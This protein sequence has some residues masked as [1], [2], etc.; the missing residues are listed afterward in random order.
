M[1]ARQWLAVLAASLPLVAG[2]CGD[3]GTPTGPR[4]SL[5]R[6]Q[7]APVDPLACSFSNAKNLAQSEFTNSTTRT[8]ARNL[9]DAMSSAGQY[10]AGAKS[11]GFSVMALIASAKKAN[12]AKDAATGSDLTNALIVCMFDPTGP[13]FPASFPIDFKPSLDRGQSGAYEVRGST[14]DALA[15]LSFPT[16]AFPRISGLTPATAS[17]SGVLHETTLIYGLPVAGTNGPDPD[18]YEWK[19]IRPNVTFQTADGGPG[20][21]VGLCNTSDVGDQDLMTETQVGYLAFVQSPPACSA[22]FAQL[23]TTW[24]RQLVDALQH[25][26]SRLFGPEPAYAA[27]MF[28]TT[29]IGGTAKG[30]KSIYSKKKLDTST[31]AV[32][33]TFVVQPTDVGV[34]KVMSP[35][36]QILATSGSD[37]V[38]D[39]TLTI[40]GVTNNGTP[41]QVKC[42][43]PS[44]TP[45]TVTT[46]YGGIA[47]IQN[48]IITKTGALQLVVTGASITDRPAITGFGLGKNSKKVNVR[49]K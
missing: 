35:N 22:T 40:S 47:T 15:V 4:E 17:W 1:V 10:T 8:T 29:S 24:E 33:F 28:F 45:C 23:N 11:N 46:A 18:Q 25:V 37:P 7:S 49:P 36:V 44:V 27:T 6:N 16:G 39:V 32:Q 26:G 3:R 13:D 9:I 43:T 20:L 19:T 41:T 42:G 21:I 30:G 14:S 31:N 5:S 2:A 12:Q 38:A 48:L 34:N